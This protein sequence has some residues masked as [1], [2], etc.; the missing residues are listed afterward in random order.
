MEKLTQSVRA[1]MMDEYDRAAE[2]YGETHASAHE[3]FAVILE[4]MQEAQGVI[5]TEVDVSVTRFW[6]ATKTNKPTHQEA[7]GIMCAAIAAAAELIQVAAMAYK[8]TLPYS[9]LDYAEEA[10]EGAEDGE[11]R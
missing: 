9:G 5:N 3:A 1:A 2:K 10:A 7:A 11:E 4:E 6:N 8:A